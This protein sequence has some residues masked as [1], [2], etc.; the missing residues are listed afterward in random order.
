MN[1]SE[2]LAAHPA[3]ILRHEVLL[4]IIQNLKEPCIHRELAKMEHASNGDWII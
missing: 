2:L 3:C 4:L 1:L